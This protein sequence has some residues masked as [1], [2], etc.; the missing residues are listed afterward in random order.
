VGDTPFRFDR[1]SDDILATHDDLQ[2]LELG[3]AVTALNTLSRVLP[4]L[5]PEAVVID[6]SPRV[7]PPPIPAGDVGAAPPVAA[8]F[9]AAALVASAVAYRK[10]RPFGG[11]R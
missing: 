11:Q 5:Q 6:S 7:T 9:L 8:L 10:R 2:V 1:L 3:L 4:L